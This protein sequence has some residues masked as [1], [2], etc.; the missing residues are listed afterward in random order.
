LRTVALQLP[1]SQVSFRNIKSR[2]Y[3][4]IKPFTRSDLFLSE[5]MFISAN[6]TVLIFVPSSTLVC[7]VIGTVVKVGFVRWG[8]LKFCVAAIEKIDSP[9][10][11]I[12]SIVV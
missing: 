11:N 10:D 1:S 8:N 6:R 4:V 2:L 3:E 5:Q 12:L 7:R 9:W